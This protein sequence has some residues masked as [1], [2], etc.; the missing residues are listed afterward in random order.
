V[1]VY[2]FYQKNYLDYQLVQINQVDHLL[3]PIVYFYIKKV[4]LVVYHILMK[5]QIHKQLHHIIQVDVIQKLHVYQQLKVK[6]K[7]YH[8]LVQII[9]KIFDF[10]YFHVH[11]MHLNNQYHLLINFRVLLKNNQ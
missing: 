10:N 7:E 8:H 11:Q 1:V 3:H 9:Q 2:Q 4:K 5:I 6:I